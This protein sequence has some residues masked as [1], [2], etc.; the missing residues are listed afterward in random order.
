LKKALHHY[1]APRILSWLPFVKKILP[2]LWRGDRSPPNGQPVQSWRSISLTRS[3]RF[4]FDSGS[5]YNHQ[6]PKSIWLWI[7]IPIQTPLFRETHSGRD[8]ACRAFKSPVQNR[9][10]WFQNWDSCSTKS[11]FP[12]TPQAP[13]S[14]KSA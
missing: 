13:D 4:P 1:P 7:A 5:M 9:S 3:S 12:H 10:V 11:L 2:G 14:I 6:N 8:A